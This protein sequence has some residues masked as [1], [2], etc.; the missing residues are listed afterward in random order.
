MVPHPSLFNNCLLIPHSACPGC[1]D[2]D[3]EAIIIPPKVE[4]MF[5]NQK[6][7]LTCQVKVN[8]PSVEKIYWEDDQGNQMAGAEKY[9]PK[10]TTGIITLKLEMSLKEWIEGEK[11]VC[12]VVHDDLLE[13]L[14]I[15]YERKV[16][17]KTM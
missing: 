3:V 2:S 14:K 10:G 12:I 1:P 5:L 9:P 15:P 17:K 16:G 11:R 4:D 7:T 13:Q 8:K 6:G